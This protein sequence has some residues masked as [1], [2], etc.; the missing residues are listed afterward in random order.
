MTQLHTDYRFINGEWI[1]SEPPE[2]F[3]NAISDDDDWGAQ[4]SRAGATEVDEFGGAGADTI[5][6]YEGPAGDYAIVFWDAAKCIA[7]VF[8]DNIP[9][10]LTFK[11]RVIAPQ[12]ML[13]MESDRE[14]E[15][16]RDRAKL[17]VAS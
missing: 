8:I 15:R 5:A 7:R 2:W 3:A 13:I 12:S 9:D 4:L 6:I 16:Q 11:A 10:Y 17:R 14:F 1:R